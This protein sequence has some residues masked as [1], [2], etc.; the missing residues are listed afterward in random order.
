MFLHTVCSERQVIVKMPIEHSPPHSQAAGFLLSDLLP[1]NR[2]DTAD[3]TPAGSRKRARTGTPTHDGVRL[4]DQISSDMTTTTTNIGAAVL[5]IKHSSLKEMA[6]SLHI[7]FNEIMVKA[8]EKEASNMSDLAGTITSLTATIQELSEE[9]EGLK[10]ELLAVKA[11]R[12]SQQVKESVKEMETQLKEAV[13]KVKVMDLNFGA[14]LT[15]RKQ[16][17]GAT[18]GPALMP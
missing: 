12:E 8:F 2:M 3:F 5:N 16:R 9:N 17:S 11:I 6:A 14:C 15:N 4:I 18:S 1:S 10:D 13:T 7:L